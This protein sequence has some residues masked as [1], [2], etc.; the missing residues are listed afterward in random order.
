[1]RDWEKR[2]VESFWD[3]SLRVYALPG[4]QD[5]CIVLQD[6]RGADV[7]ALLLALWAGCRGRRLTPADFRSLERHVRPWRTEVIEPLRAARRALKRLGRTDAAAQLRSA[8]AAAELQA[9]RQ[10][11]MMMEA[12]LP[13]RDALEAKRLVEDNLAAYGEAADVD[14]SGPAAAVLATASRTGRASRE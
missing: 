4:V 3:Y 7:N 2:S 8:V 11:Q 5:A 14:L 12:L 9:E 10:Q 13:A 1:M 6:E